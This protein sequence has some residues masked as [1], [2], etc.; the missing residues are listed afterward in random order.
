MTVEN[1]FYWYAFSYSLQVFINKK[2]TRQII[3][4]TLKQHFRVT[5]TDYYDANIL[6][7][8][9]SIKAEIL[10]KRLT[11]IAARLVILSLLQAVGTSG[12]NL[13]YNPGE[14]NINGRTHIVV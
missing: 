5:A 9:I 3:S 10:Q 1:L 8:L 13:R 11:H 2:I 6:N 7:L 12:V 14:T 4:W